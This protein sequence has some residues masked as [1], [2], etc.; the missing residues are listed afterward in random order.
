MSNAAAEDRP[1]QQ[2]EV[3]VTAPKG[4]P[5]SEVRG[6]IEGRFSFVPSTFEEAWRFAQVIAKS[7]L[8]PKD[9]QGEPENVMV[10]VQMGLD[11]GIAPMQAL[12]GIAVINGR[13]SVW[14]DLALAVVRAS[15]LFEW[16]DEQ[17]SPNGEAALCRIKRIGEEPVE[18]SFSMVDAKTAGL[19]GKE[20]PW[21]TY[22][23]RMLQMR[24]RSWAMRDAF[25]DVLRGISIREELE[26]I[27]L[28]RKPDGSFERPRRLS[29]VPS[30][31]TAPA[32]SEAPASTQASDAPPAR[33]SDTEG[34]E[35]LDLRPQ[36]R[37]ATQPIRADGKIISRIIALMPQVDHRRGE[38]GAAKAMMIELYD[39][40][41][42]TKLTA[43]QATE[44]EEK[45]QATLRAR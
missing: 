17:I 40:D 14:G 10:A 18:R 25:A 32:A 23:R 1:Q 36:E 13:P 26:D 19:A 38:R 5:A 43:E 15:P 4:T 9:Y 3:P 41:T 31:G 35:K 33:A 28:E 34:R 37:E 45:L 22:P 2:P 29:T 11:L 39:A 27:E 7:K 21:R 44:F 16:I 30:S 42:A 12:Q 20:G 24:A 8:V 6:A